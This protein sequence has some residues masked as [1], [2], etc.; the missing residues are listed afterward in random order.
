MNATALSQPTVR[1]DATANTALRL[2]NKDSDDADLEPP[3]KK[4]ATC[5]G[6]ESSV[7]TPSPRRSAPPPPLHLVPPTPDLSR[8]PPPPPTPPSPPHSSLIV[9]NKYLILDPIEGSALHSCVNVHTQEE[10]VCKMI[11]RDSSQLLTAHHR[12][13]GEAHM[14]RL[15]E[16][17]Q[18]PH[19]CHHTL[20]VFAVSHGDLHSHVRCRKR[21]REP[22]ARRLFRQMATAV[23]ACHRNGVVLRDLKLRKFVFSDPHR[24]ELKLE[25]LEDAV[26][27]EDCEDDC[28][29]DKRGCPAYVSP[30]IL[31][32][33]ARYS[34]RA[35]D[36]WSLGVIL[37][38]ML[39]GRYPFN[40]SE[41]ASLFAKISRGHFVIPDCV[42]SRAKCLIRSLL[43][44]DPLERLTA[45]DVLL[46]PWLTRDE[47]C[48]NAAAHHNDQIVPEWT[49]AEEDAY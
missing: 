40:D 30:E 21:L 23:S 31:R 2:R 6:G 38:T 32:S 8:C 27:L 9:G 3:L 24:T 41:H 18:L 19:P 49:A 22:E 12:L 34:G 29:R 5:L 44:R 10:F 39:V 7:P 28:L 33:H 13:D 37:Y 15:H 1:S 26:V 20:L 45:D 47:R 42:S 46:H 36:I 4:A 11:G 14:N 17:L 35:A 48:V 16:V 43:R 25:T